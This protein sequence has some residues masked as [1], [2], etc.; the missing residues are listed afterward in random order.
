MGPDAWFQ[1][2]GS[3]K[4]LPSVREAPRFSDG[5]SCFLGQ[6]CS[7]S[8][9]AFLS[10]RKHECACLFLELCTKRLLLD[11]LSPSP[12]PIQT[13]HLLHEAFCEQRLS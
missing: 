3:E 12:F 2:P 5:T 7:L 9:A 11:I 8:L 13:C 10:G 4:V 6:A 1:A